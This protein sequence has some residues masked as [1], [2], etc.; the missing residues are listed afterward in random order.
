MSAARAGFGGITIVLDAEPSSPLDV[1]FVAMGKKLRDFALDD[2]GDPTLPSSITFTRL[3]PGEY[4]VQQPPTA[5]LPSLRITCTSDPHGGSGTS[6][7]T[8][9]LPN[10]SMTIRLERDE[11][12][13]CTYR[14]G[15][16]QPGDVITYNQNS[17]GADP[18][19]SDAAAILGLNFDAIYVSGL[20]VGIPGAAGFSMV[21]SAPGAVLS[22]LPAIGVI[23]TLTAD[24]LD[25]TSGPSGSFG[26]NVLALAL[27]IDFSDAG[28]TLGINGIPVG[29]ITICDFTLL[30]QVNGLTVLQFLGVANTIL[31]GG[32]AAFG[33]EEANAVASILNN[34]FA[35][36]APS[37]FAQDNLVTGACP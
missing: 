35:A 21:F 4:T 17:W 27:N 7:N 12:V 24:L 20:E 28:P 2:D 36:G 19:T 1:R 15:P 10:R 25:P 18:L 32:T 23:G 22:Y 26:G 6:N 9:D 34:A 13:V 11:T 8:P 33:A 37:T 14:V 30:P 5:G 16:W 3:K 29:D 31:G